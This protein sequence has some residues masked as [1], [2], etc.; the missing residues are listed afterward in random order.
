MLRLAA[1]LYIL[2]ASAVAGAAVIAVLTL[3][4]R[5]GWQIASAF[6]AGLVIALPIAAVLARRIYNALQGPKPV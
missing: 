2:V 1:V 6:G 5:Q 4:M 3:D